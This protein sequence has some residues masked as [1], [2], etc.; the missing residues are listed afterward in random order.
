MEGGQ[1]LP[2]DSDKKDQEDQQKLLTTSQ[3]LFTLPKELRQRKE[4]IL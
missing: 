1:R 2:G 4:V 3:D